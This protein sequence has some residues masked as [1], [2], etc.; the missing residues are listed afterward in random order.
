MYQSGQQAIAVLH[1]SV[2]RRRICV[3]QTF[4][5]WNISENDFR[6]SS[7]SCHERCRVLAHVMATMKEK[8]NGGEEGKGGK[9]KGKTKEKRKKRKI[10]MGQKRRETSDVGL[11]LFPSFLSESRDYG[12]V[13][14]ILRQILTLSSIFI[15]HIERYALLISLAHL[16]PVKLMVKTNEH[17]GGTWEPQE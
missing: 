12:I 1:L 10:K 11:S 8:G 14:S 2:R 5:Y 15:A 9:K 3:L 4:W 16:N 7:S 13:P 6:G 17:R